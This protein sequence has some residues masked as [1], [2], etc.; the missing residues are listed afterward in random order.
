MASIRSKDNASTEQA[1]AKLLRKN[2]I[3]G[4]RRQAKDLPGTPDFVF[5]R[6]RVA[7]FVDGCF[8][9]GCPQCYRRPSTNSEF[10]ANK[11]KANIARDRRAVRRLRSVGWRSIRIREHVLRKSPDSAVRR[12]S[13]ALGK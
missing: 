11:I 9:H 4:W 1:L 12:V 10:W 5:R 7:V 8:W 3:S 13:A 6:E 2:K